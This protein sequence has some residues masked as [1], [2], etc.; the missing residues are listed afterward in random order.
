MHHMENIAEEVTAD[1]LLKI[2]EIKVFS[3]NEKAG[4]SFQS[5]REK[6]DH[7]EVDFNF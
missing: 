6:F 4:L 5:S 2:S 3:E 1:P 7:I